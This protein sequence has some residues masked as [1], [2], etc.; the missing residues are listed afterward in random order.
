MKGILGGTLSVL[1]ALVVVGTATADPCWYSIQSGHDLGFDF[2]IQ[3]EVQGPDDRGVTAYTYHIFRVD[4]GQITYRDPSHFSLEFACDGQAAADLVIGGLGGIRLSG[5]TASVCDLKLADSP[6]GLEEPGLGTDCRL[7][8]L[9]ITFCSGALVPDG[10]G[11]SYPDDPDDPV[12]TIRFLAL[13]KAQDGAWFAKGGRKLT[14]DLGFGSSAG[15]AVSFLTDGGGLPVPGCTPV[16]PVE[17][18][19]WGRVKSLYR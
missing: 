4:E 10:D 13:G 5:E 9:K 8:G 16:V 19:S 6:F 15:R 14:G 2:I 17:S 1:C 11:I 18:V 7:N 12:L 3:A